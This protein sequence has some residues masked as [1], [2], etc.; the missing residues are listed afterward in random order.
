MMGD[1]WVLDASPLIVSGSLYLRLCEQY[2]N[3]ARS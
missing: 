2:E 3:E 1:V